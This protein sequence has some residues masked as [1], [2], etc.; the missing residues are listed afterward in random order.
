M[1]RISLTTHTNDVDTSRRLLPGLVPFQARLRRGLA[2]THV[3]NIPAS[4][5]KLIVAAAIPEAP[6]APRVRRFRRD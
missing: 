4:N 6:R 5:T 3:T 2:G 1:A